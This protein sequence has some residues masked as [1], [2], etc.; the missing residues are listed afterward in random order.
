MQEGKGGKSAKT[1]DFIIEY[2]LHCFTKGPNKHK[3]ETLADYDPALYYSD[4][5]ET[6]IFCFN[7]RALSFGLPDIVKAI[8]TKKC[9]HTGKGN[10]FIIELPN[11][12]NQLEEYEV[13][14]NVARSGAKLRLFVESAFIRDNEHESSQPKKKKINFF[15]IAYNRQINKNIK[16]PK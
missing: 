9:F 7:R 6:R 13:Y 2:G 8:D 12:N 10:F 14:F 15:V 16:V 1:Y 3:G 11:E 5:R 4:S